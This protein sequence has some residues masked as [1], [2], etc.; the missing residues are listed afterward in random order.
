MSVI[1]NAD[2]KTFALMNNISLSEA[3]KMV[4]EQINGK[5]TAECKNAEK[6]SCFSDTFVSTEKT[7]KSQSGNEALSFY[8]N[9]FIINAKEEQ[10][11]QDIENMFKSPELLGKSA[12][13]IAKVFA[14]AFDIEEKDANEIFNED[15]INEMMETE[16]LQESQNN[17]A[18]VDEEIAE[19]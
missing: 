17:E 18:T 8:E 16:T 13:E 2:M 10:V 1:T 3:K 4:G 14:K 12:E 15:F 6:T 9:F 7:Q 5:N 11:S 19:A